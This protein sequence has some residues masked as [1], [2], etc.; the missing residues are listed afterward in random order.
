M[1]VVSGFTS[2]AESRRASK[3]CLLPFK[4]DQRRGWISRKAPK[5]VSDAYIY[6]VAPLGNG[7]TISLRR[8]PCNCTHRSRR[9]CNQ[10]I[11]VPLSDCSTNTAVLG[12][13]TFILWGLVVS[14]AVMGARIVFLH[15]I[16]SAMARFLYSVVFSLLLPVI[17]IRLLVRARKAPAYG[18]RWLERFGL[19][20][21]TAPEAQD[22]SAIW[23][24]TVSVGEFIAA[25]PLIEQVLAAYPD[26]H[27]VITTTTPTGSDQ[28]KKRFADVL[29]KRLTHVYL[30]YD[31]PWFLSAFLRRIKPQLL[32]ILETELWPNLIHSCHKHGVKVLVA[33]AR[34]SEKSAKG[35]GKVAKLSA[36]MLSHIDCLAVQNSVDAQRF[37]DLGMKPSQMQ[38]TGSIKFDLTIQ[39]DLLNQGIAWRRCW[40]EARKVVIVASTHLGED[41]IALN[42]FN[43]L[44]STAPNAM[45]VIVPRHPERFD[46]VAKLIESKHLKL[47]RRS[48]EGQLN[49][50]TQVLL[51]DTMGELMQFLAAS[52]VCIMGGSY[53]ENGGH[54]PLEPAALSVPILMGPSQFNFLLICQQLEAAGGLLTVNEQDL[55][56]VLTNWLQDDALIAQKGEQA[57][58]VVDSN[59][60]AKQKVFN[61]IA[62]HLRV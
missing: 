45:L 10:L 56:E 8:A 49:E 7:I 36:Q 15:R 23:F 22:K 5:G 26:K 32:V 54:N 11:E 59:R 61:L 24:H 31:L 34:L 62:Q 18:E 44:L 43:A 35:Y 30:P 53:V 17:L 25:I 38:V 12:C 51:V 47:A 21:A 4:E 60:G 52:D 40:G 50:Q 28:V 46:Q 14:I 39:Q 41:E 29:G 19:V 42:A 6:G 55:A 20:K 33:N 57:K 13:E 1:L 16:C 9:D 3:K 37:V 27:M 48:Q 58:Q 2:N